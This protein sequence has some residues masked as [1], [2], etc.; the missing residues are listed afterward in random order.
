MVR[1]VDAC[2]RF[3]RWLTPYVDDELDAVHCIEVEQHLAGCEQCRERVALGRAMR[4]SLRL[5]GRMQAPAGLRERLAAALDEERA[6]QAAAARPAHEAVPASLAGRKHQGAQLV[7]LKYIFPLAAAAMFVLILGGLW[8]RGDSPQA[9]RP[10]AGTAATAASVQTEPSEPGPK[11]AP[12]FPISFPGDSES[13]ELSWPFGPGGELTAAS[14][15]APLDGLIED[16]VAHHVAQQPPETT[17]PRTLERYGRDVGVRVARPQF[18]L[19]GGRY[20][21]ARMR[22]VIGNRAAVLQYMMRNSHRVTVYV[23]DPQ[24]VPMQARLLEPR[25]IGTQ[26][27]FVGRLRGYSVAASSGNG[28]GYALASDLGDEESSE[29]VLAAAR[30]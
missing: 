2:V 18:E 15:L 12:A 3:E 28:V 16:L 24:R 7:Q 8:H 23:F 10:V 30:R 27:V 13:A 6:E 9:D 17:D 19:Y 29:L 4:G 20:L 25:D 21:G 11:A 1:L 14:A 5:G 26:H 22:P